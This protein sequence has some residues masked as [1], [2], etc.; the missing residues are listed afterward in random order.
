MDA[1]MDLVWPVV[2]LGFTLGGFA[3]GYLRGEEDA[4]ERVRR[5]RQARA[6]A[7]NDLLSG[8]RERG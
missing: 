3:I 5:Q 4:I 6:K 7:V 8:M 1:I 2:C